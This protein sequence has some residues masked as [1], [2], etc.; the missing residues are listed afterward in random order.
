VPALAPA[1]IAETTST[2]RRPATASGASAD[3][4]TTST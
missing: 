3:A 1:E 2:R 4:L